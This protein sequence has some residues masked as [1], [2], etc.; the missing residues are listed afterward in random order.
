MCWRKSNTCS[1]DDKEP[2]RLAPPDT[3]TLAQNQPLSVA[4]TVVRQQYE[5][6]DGDVLEYPS[7]FSSPARSEDEFA[8]LSSTRARTASEL[9]EH[10]KSYFPLR[11]L[12]TPSITSPF[13]KPMKNH[14]SFPLL[15]KLGL[16]SRTCK[17]LERRCTV[18]G[19]SFSYNEHSRLTSP[20]AVSP[21]NPE[22]PI[23]L[24]QLHYGSSASCRQPTSPTPC[25]H[26]TM[27]FSPEQQT[28]TVTMLSITGTSHRLEEMSVLGSLAPLCPCPA[29]ASVR[30]SLSPEPRNLNLVFKVGIV[31][32]LQRCVLRLA[33]YTRDLPSLRG[34]PLGELEV[35]CRGK[36][37]KADHPFHYTKE[38]SPNKWKLI[39]VG[40]CCIDT[41][42]TEMILL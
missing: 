22:E 37:W 14:A 42:M 38:F 5:E 8:S 26:F 30:C 27:A 1:F 21:S 35:Q 11:R 3:V 33:L 39:K 31:E 24:A 25:L 10:P 6:L 19:D 36:D 7:T 28:L 40:M 29:Q 20:S 18:T 15:P 34:S 13:Y 2:V 23:P 17:V 4:T 12:S 16:L 32:E 9:K 41:C